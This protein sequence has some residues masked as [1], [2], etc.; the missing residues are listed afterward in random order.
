MDE[1]KIKNTE[2]KVIDIL[3]GYFNVSSENIKPS[4]RLVEDLGIDSMSLVELIFELK[5]QFGVEIKKEDIV[6]IRTI[7]DV[8]DFIKVHSK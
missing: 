6:K 4:S 1:S 8:T 3:S 7:K 2:K 5:E